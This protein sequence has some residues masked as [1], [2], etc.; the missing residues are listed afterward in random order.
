MMAPTAQP[1]RNRVSL[2]AAA[3]S[4]AL[5]LARRAT[6]H[7]PTPRL[8]AFGARTYIQLVQMVSPSSV[9]SRVNLA[10]AT[11]HVT[12]AT[13]KTRSICHRMSRR[14]RRNRIRRH[15]ASLISRTSMAHWMHTSHQQ[16]HPSKNHANS[17]LLNSLAIRHY[18]ISLTTF[19][20]VCV[21]MSTL[22]NG[23]TRSRLW[24]V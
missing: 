1:P 10:D 24:T 7:A 11:V 17:S 21:S 14:T 19:C 23:V 5:L 20:C 8:A 15:D 2:L 9:V 13:Q 6:V 12:L 3:R 4:T 22:N 18:L 16:S